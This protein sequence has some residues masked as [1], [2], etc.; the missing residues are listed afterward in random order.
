[1][2]NFSK[3]AVAA[4]AALLLTFASV[5]PASAVTINLP[6]KI[7]SGQQVKTTSYA[8]YS[9]VHS[10]GTGGGAISWNFSNGASYTTNA[11][12]WGI[13]AAPGPGNKADGFYLSSASI[14]CAP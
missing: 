11:R 13:S 9:V 14:S 12:Y 4:C 3:A 8:K 5:S 1:M 7:C 2:K 6:Y 10:I